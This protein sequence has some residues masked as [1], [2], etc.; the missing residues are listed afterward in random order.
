MQQCHADTCSSHSSSVPACLC[1]HYGRPASFALLL[2]T[3]PPLTSSIL[4]LQPPHPQPAC[5]PC[6][7]V[8]CRF[9]CLFWFMARAEGFSPTGSWVGRATS[10][11]EGQNAG[12]W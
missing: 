4:H 1:A 10:R 9:A 11:F 8:M 5:T 7:A 6:S 3:L 12:I 2:S